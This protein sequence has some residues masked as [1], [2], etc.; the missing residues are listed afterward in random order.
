LVA[1][2]TGTNLLFRS[3]EGGTKDVGAAAKFDAHFELMWDAAQPM[4]EFAPAINAL[5][6]S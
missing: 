5:Q 2:R 6:P 3:A 4:I 1:V